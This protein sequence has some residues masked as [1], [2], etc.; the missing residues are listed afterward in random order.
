[1]T[2]H[3]GKYHLF[4]PSPTGTDPELDFGGGEDGATD[5]IN[6]LFQARSFLA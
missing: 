4:A 3:V 5:S 1:M 2:G 6:C